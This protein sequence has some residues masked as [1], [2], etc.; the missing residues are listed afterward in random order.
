MGAMLPKPVESTV[1]E[2]QASKEFSVAVAEMN[3][4]RANMEDAHVIHMKSTWGFFGVFD[5]HGGDKCSK[6]VAKRFSEELE[7]KGCPEDDA[8]VKQL[9]LSIDQEFLDSAQ[10]SGSTATMCIVHKPTGDGKHKLRVVNAGDSRVLLGKRDGT[11]VDG[12]GTDSGLTTDHKPNH[13]SERERIYRC[14]GHVEESEGG[15]ARVNG[16]LA[17]SRGFG[18]A[19][20]KKTGGPGPED[21]PV[22]ADPEL[23]NF[24]CDEADFL[25]LVCDGVSEGDFSNPEVVKLVADCLSE[26]PDPA[27]AA[28][29]VCHKAVERN[30]KDNIT[31]MLVLFTG[32]DEKTEKQIEFNP[33]PLWVTDHRQFV[34]AWIAMA[35]KANYTLPQ[36]LEKRFEVIQ[37][38]LK[39]SACSDAKQ[40]Q[41][42]EELAKLG[43][44]EGEK[45]GQAAK[46]HWDQ[47]AK[48]I[49]SDDDHT[50][51]SQESGISMGLMRMLAQ[52]PGGQHALMQ[53]LGANGPRG[54]VQPAGRRVIAP[55]LETLKTAVEQHSKLSWDPRLANLAGAE[56]EVRKDDPSDGT[57]NVF[58]PPPIGLCAWLP[59][60]ILKDV[61]PS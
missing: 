32:P 47:K 8:A 1:V 5:G 61:P 2:R 52:H 16:D 14:G 31:C 34:N 9:V 17:V 56:G 20:Y 39:D 24:E 53:I 36:A 19:D 44:P 49:M 46:E 3:G 6:F 10:E 42:K 40:E 27:V 38:E 59:T 30:S 28:K 48:E 51:S 4:W 11:I 33:G 55:G 7:S 22:T 60:D 13:P 21:H 35:A 45:G 58:F 41:L 12:G 25:L 15:V 29:A 57:T 54:A 18:D 26:N 23:G 43:S 50:E 37:E